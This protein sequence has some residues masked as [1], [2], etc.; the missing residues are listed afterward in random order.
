MKGDCFQASYRSFMRR[1]LDSVSENVILAHGQVVGVHGAL[2]DVYHWHC[3]VEFDLP[4]L[5]VPGA[6]ESLRGLTINVNVRDVKASM[7]RMVED[8]SNDRLAVVSLE[9]FTRLARQQ[10]VLCYDAADVATNLLMF[11]HFGPWDG[12]VLPSYL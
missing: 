10:H 2:K 1:S 12:S 5:M 8:S 4:V 3:W 11:G 9:F 7:V 6:P